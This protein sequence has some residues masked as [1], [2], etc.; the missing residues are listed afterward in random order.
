LEAS[1]AGSAAFAQRGVERLRRLERRLRVRASG[2]EDPTCVGRSL[3]GR[4]TI[5][6][7]EV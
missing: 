7:M 3:S 1:E 6:P 2:P 4:R 5:N